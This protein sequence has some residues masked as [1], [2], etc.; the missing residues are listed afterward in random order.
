[1]VK[2]IKNSCSFKDSKNHPQSFDSISK[3]FNKTKK[4]IPKFF[5]F[6]INSY[7]DFNDSQL[8]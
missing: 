5:H 4:K 8:L 1:M 7:Y 2:K 3:R 6:N